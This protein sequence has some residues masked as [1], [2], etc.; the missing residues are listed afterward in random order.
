MFGPVRVAR[1]EYA[2]SAPPTT[3][4]VHPLTERQSK[5]VLKLNQRCFRNGENYTKHTFAYLFNEP[6]SISYQIATANGE[7][8]AFTF[9]LLNPD[10]AAH[11]TTIGVAPEHRRRG[12]A[13][14]LLSHLDEVLRVKGVSTIVLE[15]RVSNLPAKRLYTDSGYSLINRLKNYYSDGE[16]CFLMVKSLV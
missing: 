7:M 1:N 16:D 13:A 9:V 15:L 2:V 5:E 4:S 6:R 3:Y 10:G 14:K 11:L 12:L 8:A